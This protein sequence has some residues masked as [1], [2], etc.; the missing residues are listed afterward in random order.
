[1]IN[2]KVKVLT[3]PF[4]NVGP[5]LKELTK[6]FKTM[7]IVEIKFKK[8]LKIMPTFCSGNQHSLLSSVS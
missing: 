5:A 2:A 3:R 6:I 4:M 8:V 7:E 1:M